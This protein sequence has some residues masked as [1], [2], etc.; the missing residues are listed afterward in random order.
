[1]PGGGYRS[2]S[3]DAYVGTG[4]GNTPCLIQLVGT[5][6]P[7]AIALRSNGDPQT[8][9]YQV[10]LA[11][12]MCWGSR[13]RPGRQLPAPSPTNPARTPPAPLPW[14]LRPHPR[15]LLPSGATGRAAL[16]LGTRQNGAHAGQY[17]LGQALAWL[18]EP[19]AHWCWPMYV[20]VSGRQIKQF[21]AISG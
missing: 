20:W 6:L 4:N 2:L 18:A 19:P 11:M 21:G 12:A 7:A 9:Y 16:L 15:S 10:R 13:A 1:M 8:G 17:L 3:S 5:A 14:M